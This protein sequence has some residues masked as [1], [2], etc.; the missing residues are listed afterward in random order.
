MSKHDA[1]SLKR[2]Q[3]QAKEEYE[4]LVIW[5]ATRLTPQEVTEFTHRLSDLLQK[6]K[7]VYVHYGLPT[8]EYLDIPQVLLLNP[9]PQAQKLSFQLEQETPPEQE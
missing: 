1:E 6:R 9:Q 3:Q 8:A 2:L 4:Q 5:I 7:A